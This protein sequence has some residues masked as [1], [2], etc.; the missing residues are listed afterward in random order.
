MRDVSWRWLRNVLDKD[1]LT[2]PVDNETTACFYTLGQSDMVTFWGP[3][4][5]A[6]YLL[7]NFWCEFLFR[8]MWASGRFVKTFTPF[9]S[10]VI[11]FKCNV[12]TFKS[13]Y[14][15]QYR[16]ICMKAE[17]EQYLTEYVR[18]IFFIILRSFFSSVQRMVSFYCDY[19]LNNIEL[20]P[21]IYNSPCVAGVVGNLASQNM[22]PGQISYEMPPHKHGP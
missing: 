15:D 21:K 17:P 13:D 4:I 12:K 18:L 19:H 2:M 14:N 9:D 10:F 20:Y 11:N 5:R 3:I 16:V 22:P 7:R 8:R 1:R 6:V